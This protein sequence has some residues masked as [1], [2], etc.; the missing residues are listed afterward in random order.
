MKA[1]RPRVLDL[2]MYLLR[3]IRGMGRAQRGSKWHEGDEA[4]SRG[5][6]E[7]SWVEPEA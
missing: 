5:L 7:D 3:G 4:P 2:I 1:L 6:C